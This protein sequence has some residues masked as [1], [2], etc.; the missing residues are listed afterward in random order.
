MQDEPPQ[1]PS[2][3][4]ELQLDFLESR[5]LGALMEKQ[6]TTP[7]YY[8]MTINGLESACNQSSNR[9][10]VTNFNHGEIEEA[11]QR[12]R[13]KKLVVHMI[14]S[15]SRV[16]KYQHLLENVLELTSA[17]HAVMT[18]LLLR[19]TQT[20]GEIKQR[21]ERLHPFQSVEQVEET[22]QGFIEYPNGPLVQEIAAGGGRRVKTYAHL[23]GGEPGAQTAITPQNTATTT[24]IE[25]DQ[26]HWK[27]AME[28]RLTSLEGALEQI[29][30]EISTIKS[31]LGLESEES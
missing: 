7:A 1:S 23:L 30:S 9:A 22:L 11:I 3:F 24:I 31:E 27:T 17:E 4:P 8:P 10:P 26:T 2:R 29:L 5:V 13:D 18:V 19:S 16:P 21:T 14:V 25:N 6:V 12:L 20:A 15:G 28:N